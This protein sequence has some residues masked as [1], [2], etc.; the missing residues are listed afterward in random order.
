MNIN[1][2]L[3]DKVLADIQKDVEAKDLTVIEELLK[4]CPEEVLRGFLRKEDE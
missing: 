2:E 1:Q 4:S 3:I